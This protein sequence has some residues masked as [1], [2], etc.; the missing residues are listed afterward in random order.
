MFFR[1][2][3]PTSPHALG[4][5][6]AYTN[7]LANEASPHLLLHKHNP[8]DRFPWRKEALERAH[9]SHEQPD[10]ALEESR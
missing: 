4:V 3:N 10:R 9:T 2:A 1:H 8:N 7:R 5:S 6:V